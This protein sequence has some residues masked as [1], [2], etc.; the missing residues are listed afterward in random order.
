MTS[1]A[2]ASTKTTFKC[3]YC[4]ATFV[5]RDLLLDH[6]AGHCHE[7]PF[8]P[9]RVLPASDDD[10]TLD[11]GGA[12]VCLFCSNSRYRHSARLTEHIYQQHVLKLPYRCAMCNTAYGIFTSH[13]CAAGDEQSTVR[14]T[15]R[16]VRCCWR[17][18]NVQDS[19]R[20]HKE[21]GKAH[22][23][24]CLN[25][26]GICHPAEEIVQHAR[27]DTARSSTMVVELDRA[28]GAFEDTKQPEQ[29]VCC[30]CNRYFRG[31]AGLRV[32]MHTHASGRQI[33]S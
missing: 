16:C 7:V 13:K 1:A 23:M 11:P 3:Y 28:V 4:V 12:H 5:R 8:R 10:I 33:G 22:V 17:F 2:A 21:N 6:V 29:R 25:C 24:Q 15:H 20:H 14:W 9:W 27:Q 30:L 26:D 18:K 32:H 31:K 19:V